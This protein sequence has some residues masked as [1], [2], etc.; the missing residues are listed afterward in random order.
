MRGA[1][2]AMDPPSEVAARLREYFAMAAEAMRNQD[3]RER[4]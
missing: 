3:A 4:A 1:I 2:E